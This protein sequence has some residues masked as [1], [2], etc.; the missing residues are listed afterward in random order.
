MTVLGS[1]GFKIL[2][3]QEYGITTKG[4]SNKFEAVIYTWL[5][6]DSLASN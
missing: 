1:F 5:M 2:I 3:F 4:G 6:W